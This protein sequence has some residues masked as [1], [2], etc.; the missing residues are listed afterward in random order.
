MLI[1]INTQ[2]LVKIA[3]L[4]DCDKYAIYRN[5]FTAGFVIYAEGGGIKCFSGYVEN[6]VN[7]ILLQF[8]MNY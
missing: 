4:S 8:L 5:T 6:G 1:K 3:L 2:F 7:H